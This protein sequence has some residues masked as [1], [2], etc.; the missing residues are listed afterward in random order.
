M[1]KRKND[2]IIFKSQQN[3]AFLLNI[4]RIM[5]ALW[6]QNHSKIAHFTVFKLKPMALWRDAK[7][8]TFV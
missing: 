5:R 6:L 3:Q 8:A 7:F 4:Y 2:K 1:Q